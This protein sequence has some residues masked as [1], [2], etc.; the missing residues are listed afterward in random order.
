[1]LT[2]T[3]SSV[4]FRMVSMR[5]EKPICAPPRLSE[6]SPTLALKGFHPMFVGLT[7]ALS[8]PFKDDRSS[9]ASSFQAIGDVTSLA[10]C[11][12]VVSQAP[13]HFRSSEKQATLKI[14]T[15]PKKHLCVPGTVDGNETENR[16]T[17]GLR[18]NF[19]SFCSKQTKNPSVSAAIPVFSRCA[20]TQ[21]VLYN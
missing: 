19:S 10:L 2:F 12:Q 16:H 6:V 8:R 9:N 14:R 4:Q 21:Y 20:V 18:S 17:T 1:M 5:S 13:Q 3:I 15:K 11:L 7:M